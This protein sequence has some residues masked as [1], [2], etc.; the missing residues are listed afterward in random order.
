[1]SLD[2]NLTNVES[3]T[4]KKT[5]LTDNSDTF[6]PTQKAVKTAV[7]GKVDKITGKGLSENDFTDALKTTYDDASAWVTDVGLDLASRTTNTNTGDE[8]K[9][10][11]LSKLGWWNILDQTPGTQS[12]GVS[13]TITKSIALPS[14]PSVLNFRAVFLK[15]G[16]AANL[17]VRAYLSQ[18][19]NNIDIAGG[20]AM[21][22]ATATT[23][24][25]TNIFLPLKRTINFIGANVVGISATTQAVTDDG[26]FAS[27]LNTAFPAGTPL[28]LIFTVQCSNGSDSA[29]LNSCQINNFTF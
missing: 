29:K 11:I 17:A 21:L 18:I 24:A 19:D 20:T 6:Y 10:S 8:D 1:M 27:I 3:T 25:G 26:Q 16:T 12:S 28:Y 7:D 5:D 13:N 15:T 4:N 9:A 14:V 22:I 23:S 2:I